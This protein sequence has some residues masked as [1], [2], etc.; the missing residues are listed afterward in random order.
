MAR[1]LRMEFR[2]VFYHV[3]SRGSLRQAMFR[4]DVD[5]QKLLEMVVRYGGEVFSIVFVPNHIV[6][7][8]QRSA[9]SCLG[10]FIG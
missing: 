1:P 7:L 6:R 10:P 9:K 2:G 8:G 3:M 4:D 5:R